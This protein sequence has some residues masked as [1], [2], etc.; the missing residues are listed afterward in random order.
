[1][2]ESY[3]IRLAAVSDA[4]RIAEMSKNLIELGL[5]W[6][7]TEERVIRNMRDKDT[8]VVVACDGAHLIGFGITK[9]RINEAHIV[10]FAVEKSR[11]R[12]G[13]GTALIKW[14]EKTA[15]V[16]GIGIVY[17]EARLRNSAAREFYRAL[18]YKEFLV[19]PRRYRGV[20]TGVRLGK[21]LWE[22]AVAS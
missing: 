19:E 22:D 20:E 17:L 12:N 16:A 10:L 1:M 6:S 4:R 11:Q 3:D 7:W 9:Y 5:G 13:V 2:I 15:L 14:I 8:N 21:D 18:G